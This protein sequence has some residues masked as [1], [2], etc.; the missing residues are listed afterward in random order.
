MS[1][2]DRALMGKMRKLMYERAIFR[3]ALEELTAALIADGTHIPPTG[4][5]LCEVCDA[6]NEANQILEKFHD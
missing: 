3:K 4:N 5:G 2:R 1:A 6:L